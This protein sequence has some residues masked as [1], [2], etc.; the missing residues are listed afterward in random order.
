MNM[1]SFHQ[2]GL[3]NALVASGEVDLQVVFA[4]NLAA[5]REQLGWQSEIKTYPYRTLSQTNSLIDG[6]RIARAERRR[7]HI[8]N[9]IW[10]EPAF[11]A[12]LCVLVLARSQFAIHSEA[13]D[14]RLRPSAFKKI[15]RPSFAKW[16][17]GR[18]AG[19]FAVSHFAADFYMQLG[20][21]P[22][23]V[24]PFAYFRAGTNLALE[25]SE[26]KN[27]LQIEI[28]FVGQL[29]D[30]KGID[31]LLAAMSPLFAMY[32]E[33]KLT[34]IGHGEADTAL[35]KQAASL[36]IA[37]R[38]QF[39]GVLSSDEIPRRI[40]QANLLVLPS[41]WDGWGMVVNE[42]LAV[43]V[44]V[45]VSDRCGAADLI[46][47]GI[48]GF[49]FRSEDVGD[50]RRALRQFLENRSQWPTLHAAARLVGESL[51]TEKAAHYL[52]DC[53]KHLT[54]TSDARPIP[55]W[56]QLPLSQSTEF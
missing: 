52:I 53:L 14:P 28:V 21:A 17:A 46:Q 44:P 32:P 50:L 2:D 30:R 11:A 6:V 45:I 55:P 42:A 43:G 27:P 7:L 54:R 47:Q 15:L 5:D 1:P 22:A 36:E 56:T 31:I 39:A 19:L 33:L 3:F 16:V 41:R 24:Y 48:N 40:A 34:I 25:F 26:S 23:R 20:F 8:I 4:R 51:S 37:E 9:G 35:K 29:I 38:V 13:P 49:I 12:A 10:A 18:A